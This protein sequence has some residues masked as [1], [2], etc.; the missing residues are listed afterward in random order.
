M[1]EIAKNMIAKNSNGY[2]DYSYDKSSQKFFHQGFLT[3]S[4]I[5]FQ[6]KI[7]PVYSIGS[8][9]TVSVHQLSSLN[10]KYL[11]TTIRSITLSSLS[12]L[13]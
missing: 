10:P 8:Q 1:L 3:F 11:Q 13:P 5:I 4:Q 6:G 9:S 2:S 12:H 7:I